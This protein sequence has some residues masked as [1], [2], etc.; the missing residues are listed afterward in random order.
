LGKENFLGGKCFPRI[1]GESG[2]ILA[3]NTNL[4]GKKNK[5]LV[6]MVLS[7]G[8]IEVRNSFLEIS[9]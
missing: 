4:K 5:R 8:W 7:D 9:L 6:E 1:S 3:L 2:L